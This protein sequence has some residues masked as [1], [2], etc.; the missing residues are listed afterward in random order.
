MLRPLAS[1]NWLSKDQESLAVC[2]YPMWNYLSLMTGRLG[3]GIA[4]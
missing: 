3:M 1:V 2:P 4:A